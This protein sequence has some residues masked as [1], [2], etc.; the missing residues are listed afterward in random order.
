[1]SC[2]YDFSSHK[3]SHWTSDWTQVHRLDKKSLREFLGM[4]FLSPLLFS[5]DF[6]CE[7]NALRSFFELAELLLIVLPPGVEKQGELVDVDLFWL[8]PEDRDAGRH[9]AGVAGGVLEWR[10]EINGELSSFQNKKDDPSFL[11]VHL[12]SLKVH[13]TFIMSTS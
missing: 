9:L 13:G 6:N 12:S 5:I 3:W 4:F 11:I 7:W 2:V 10:R 1:M 8:E